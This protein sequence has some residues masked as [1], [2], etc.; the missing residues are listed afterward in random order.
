MT[1]TNAIQDAL[2]IPAAHDSQAAVQDLIAKRLDLIS[3]GTSIKRTGYFNH[4]WVPD[5][6]VR[7]KDSSVRGVFLRFDV[8][9]ASFKDDL[10]YLAQEQPLFVDIEETESDEHSSFDLSEA[11]QEIGREGVLV[12]EPEALDRFK[13]GVET[14]AEVRAATKQVV[15]G[16]H[17]HVDGR[18]AA[19]IVERWSEANAAAVEA[20]VASLRSALN[21]V[22]KYLDRNSSLDL[23][24]DLRSTWVSAGHDAEQFPGRE[25]WKLEDR[26]P[27]ELAEL[28]ASLIGREAKIPDEQ[29]EL[30]VT[31]ISASDLG[32]ELASLG[33]IFSGGTVNQLARGGLSYWTARYAY[34]PPL[35][36]DTLDGRFDWQVGKYALGI[37]L[38]RRFAYFTDNGRKWSNVP[39]PKSLPDV[40]ER[41]QRLGQ[42][43]VLGA[44][45]IT[46]EEQVSHELRSTATSS[47]ADRLEPF[48]SDD[49]SWR[50][51]RLRWLDLKVAGTDVT[52]RVDFSRAVVT[53]GGSVPLRSLVLLVAEF[54]AAL[55]EE[56][57]AELH[58][59]LP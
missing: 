54:V 26:G 56:E 49:P 3:P 42:A 9:H 51:A 35:D 7:G 20:E 57:M 46:P 27:H 32:S 25:D 15:V 37:N 23:E 13:S 41:L 28:I 1:L 10:T 31:S 8:K 19:E 4:A 30:L 53:A 44:G 2:K 50:S 33:Q 6:V 34:V 11:L 17:G 40:R 59:A 39:R 58:A 16:G 21:D 47:L 22:E 14:N 45:I 12:S 43:A 5:L 29:L 52:A 55:T 48:I 38:I 18:A 24:G 36:S